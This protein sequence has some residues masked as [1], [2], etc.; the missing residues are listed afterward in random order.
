MKGNK[1]LETVTKQIPGLLAGHLLL[2]KGKLGA[3]DVGAALK[4]IE[5]VIE[6][7]PKHMEA[8]ILYALISFQTGNVEQAYQCLEEAIANNFQVRENP[9]FMLIKGEIELKN[10]DK[11]AAL[12][13]LLA[14]FNLPGAKTANSKGKGPK[15]TQT[16]PG[17]EKKGN[18]PVL[19]LLTYTDKERCKLHIHCL[20]IIMSRKEGLSN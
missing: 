19:Q 11:E 16:Q 14:A 17:A 12:A 18:E 3:G 2:A 5:R 15:R 4:H 20:V 9:L 13:T 8:T 6:I 1:L 7:N 10:N